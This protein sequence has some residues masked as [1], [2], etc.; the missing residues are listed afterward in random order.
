MTRAQLIDKIEGTGDILHML[1]DALNDMP[2]TPGAARVEIRLAVA[3]ENL[4]AAKYAAM[5]MKEID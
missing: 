5:V 4:R 3:I 2:E 1:I